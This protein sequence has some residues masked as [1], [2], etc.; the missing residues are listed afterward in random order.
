[1][2]CDRIEEFSVGQRGVLGHRT[3]PEIQTQTRVEIQTHFHAL[4]NNPKPRTYATQVIASEAYLI[5]Q[6]A[7]QFLYSNYVDNKRDS[8]SLHVFVMFCR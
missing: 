5:D 2:P 1:M 8:K 4:R 3:I 7:T 6:N